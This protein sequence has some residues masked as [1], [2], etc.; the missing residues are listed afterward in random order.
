MHSVPNASGVYQILCV[1][2]GKV[3]VG[4]A[5]NLRIRWREHRWALNRGTHHSEYLQRAG[6]SMAKQ[7]LCF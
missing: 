4:S 3:Y 7:S 1:P 2:T 6:I 5:S